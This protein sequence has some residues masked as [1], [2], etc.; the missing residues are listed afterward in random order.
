MQE[1]KE[2]AEK[3]KGSVL[4]STFECNLRAHFQHQS[5]TAFKLKL[6]VCASLK[7]QNHVIANISRNK[8]HAAENSF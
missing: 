6:I 3:S 2:D 4:T 5:I 7:L 1:T 8:N